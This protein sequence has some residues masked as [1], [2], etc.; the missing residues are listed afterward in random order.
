M[1]VQSENGAERYERKG[2]L[3]RNG[4]WGSLKSDGMGAYKVLI[5]RLA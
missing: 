5:I 2:N 1:R 4:D 3:D